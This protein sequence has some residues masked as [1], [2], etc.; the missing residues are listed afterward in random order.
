[1]CGM[2]R[3]MVGIMQCFH[4]SVL[5]SCEGAIAFCA[6]QSCYRMVVNHDEAQ[7]A[8]QGTL[9]S[10]HYCHPKRTLNTCLQVLHKHARS[11]LRC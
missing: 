10:L 9:L 1:M 7:V 6:I 11:F 5:M 4:S 8:Q 3:L 2:E